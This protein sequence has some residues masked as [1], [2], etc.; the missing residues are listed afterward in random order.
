MGSAESIQHKGELV[1]AAIKQSGYQ[2]NP[3]ARELGI[4]RNMCIAN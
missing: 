1:E 2:V 4:V 3:L